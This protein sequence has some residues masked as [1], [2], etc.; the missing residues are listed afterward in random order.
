MTTREFYEKHG[1]MGLCD[2]AYLYIED[3]W[4][5]SL[6]DETRA[7]FSQLINLSEGRE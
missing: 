5:S 2:K 4:V 3:E 7:T 6:T 1:V